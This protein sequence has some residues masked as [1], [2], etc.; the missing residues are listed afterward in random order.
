MLNVYDLNPKDSAQLEAFNHLYKQYSLLIFDDGLRA[1]EL[2]KQV[3]ASQLYGDKYRILFSYW[4]AKAL[5]AASLYDSAFSLIQEIHELLDIPALL[6][7]DISLL[8]GRVLKYQ[9]SYSEANE[10]YSS[11]LTEY[12]K[13]GD[14][15][16]Q[17][18]ARVNIGEYYRALARYDLAKTNLD[19][20]QDLIDANSDVTIALQAYCLNRLSAVYNESNQIA[21]AK[22]IAFKTLLLSQKIESQ[23]QVAVA[24]NE[25]ASIYSKEMKQDSTLFFLSKAIDIWKKT[26]HTRYWISATGN[27]L[28]NKL[29]NGDTDDM[30]AVLIEAIRISKD[31]N[32]FGVLYTFYNQM[33]QLQLLQNNQESAIRY[34]DSLRYAL[35]LDVTSATN[36]EVAVQVANYEKELRELDFKVVEANLS[37]EKFRKLTLA[38][39][40][41]AASL[42]IAGL[43]F[44]STSLRKKNIKIR[45]ANK[46]INKSLVVKESL[47]KDLHHRVKNNL[48]FLIGLVHLQKSESSDPKT[49]GELDE[50]KGRLEVMALL[51]SNQLDAAD[52]GVVELNL[53]L[54]QLKDQVISLTGTG[55]RIELQVPSDISIRT[56]KAIILGVIINELFTN[57]LKHAFT[58]METGGIIQLKFT[59]KGDQSLIVISD[60]GVGIPEDFSFERPG[61]VGLKL[62]SL[63]TEQLKGKI[64]MDTSVNAINFT[65][66]L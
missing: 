11:A 56:D 53:M 36:K 48:A 55:H 66:D 40:L 62:I 9:Q 16:G 10:M 39:L 4:E 33:A 14:I 24:Y 1:Y 19:L 20:A 3:N 21:N 52:S 43:W 18:V 59:K 31:N 32:W 54:N 7:A 46:E 49:K 41:F 35:E 25:L 42:L 58:G 37:E 51:H 22:S 2:I 30:D 47:L 65:F 17:I 27:L 26:G 15:Q 38:A 28:S 6:K 57:A 50:I 23:F 13:Y 44:F 5:S 12:Q 29:K 8:R 45:E 61:S 64:E 34:F 60:N 63:L